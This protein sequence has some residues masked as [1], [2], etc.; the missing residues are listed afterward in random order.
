MVRAVTHIPKSMA[1]KVAEAMAPAHPELQLPR[2]IN[3]YSAHCQS[4]VT[5]KF[6]N[7]QIT[8]IPFKMPLILSLVFPTMFPQT[9]VS[10][11]NVHM[12]PSVGTSVQ[13]Q[14]CGWW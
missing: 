6:I 1:N 12:L 9:T 11:A 10:T 3:V 14:W 13:V 5:T 4:E 2:M 7:S 8:Y